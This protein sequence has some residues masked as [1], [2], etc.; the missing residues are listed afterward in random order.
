M[1]PQEVAVDDKVRERHAEATELAAEDAV[2]E[3]TGYMRREDMLKRKKAWSCL[4]KKN[5]DAQP[6]WFDQQVATHTY[7][8]TPDPTLAGAEPYEQDLHKYMHNADRT[9]HFSR[10]FVGGAATGPSFWKPKHGITGT[11]NRRAQAKLLML[12]PGKKRAALRKQELRP[13]SAPPG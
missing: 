8:S 5:A 13:D 2:R 10:D 12:P 4:V 11:E 7:F 6:C 9:F 3:T 1:S